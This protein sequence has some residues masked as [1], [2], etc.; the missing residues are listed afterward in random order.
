MDNRID[1]NINSRIKRTCFFIREDVNT[2]FYHEEGNVDFQAQ[3]EAHVKAVDPNSEFVGGVIS[4]R[5]HYFSWINP[6]YESFKLMSEH[7]Y[8]SGDVKNLF[9]ECMKWTKKYRIAFGFITT[10][11]DYPKPD[12]YGLIYYY[13]IKKDDQN[14]ID[15]TPAQKESLRGWI[16]LV[17]VPEVYSSLTLFD[18]THNVKFTEDRFVNVPMD[19]QGFYQKNYN[20]ACLRIYPNYFVDKKK[21]NEEHNI[22][23]FSNAI[24]NVHSDKADIF[25]TQY[26]NEH[27]PESLQNLELPMFIYEK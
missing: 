25:S 3:M 10:K 4:D 6:D 9:K 16:Y 12:E 11:L 23:E 5:I 27:L 19:P 8:F 15:A 1:I 26:V 20:D 18:Y 14:F 24:L 7:I 17:S 2:P 13:N 22:S 21:Y